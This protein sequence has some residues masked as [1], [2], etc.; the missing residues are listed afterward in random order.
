MSGCCE[1]KH[2]SKPAA[3][4]PGPIVKKGHAGNTDAPQKHRRDYQNDEWKHCLSPSAP[5]N[6]NSVNINIAPNVDDVN[7]PS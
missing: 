5:F 3:Q 1:Q 7:T 4:A 2:Q 6:V